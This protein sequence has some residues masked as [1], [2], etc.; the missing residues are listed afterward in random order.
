MFC[1]FTQ[2]RSLASVPGGS[3]RGKICRCM[4]RSVMTNMLTNRYRVVG[5]KRKLAF[6]N[7]TVCKVVL[8]AVKNSSKSAF[9]DSDILTEIGDLLRNAPNQ[10]GSSNYKKNSL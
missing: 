7:C 9:M 6:K 3:D 1:E 4:M 2:V 5:H 8:E 10:P